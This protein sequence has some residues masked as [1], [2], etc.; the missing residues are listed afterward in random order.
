MSTELTL[1]SKS[2]GPC[3]KCISLVGG[4]IVPDGSACAISE[5]EAFRLPIEDIANTGAKTPL[6]TFAHLL[7]QIEPRHAL[8]LGRLVGRVGDNLEVVTERRR[9]ENPQ[10]N[11]IA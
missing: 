7:S 1:I 8:C 4:K 11:V 6:W 10:P 9:R 3:T 2:N 5:G